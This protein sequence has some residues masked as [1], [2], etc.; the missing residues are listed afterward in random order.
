MSGLKRRLSNA[1]SLAMLLILS[2][3]SAI[4]YNSASVAN[5]AIV[6]TIDE[7]DLLALEYTADYIKSK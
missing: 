4:L 3:Y 2:V 7:S 5:L 1:T 6:Q